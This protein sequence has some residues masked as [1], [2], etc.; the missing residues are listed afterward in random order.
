MICVREN[1]Q[2]K[3]DGL[4]PVAPEVVKT[5]LEPEFWILLKQFHRTVAPIVDAIGNLE[6]REANLAD[7]M[8]ELIK[9]ARNF[10]RLE[11]TQGESADFW[12]HA[13]ITF[14]NRFHGMNTDLHQLALF[15]HPLCRNLA[16]GQA[17]N[18]RSLKDMIKI[19]L[20]IAH[21]QWDWSRVRAEALQQNMNDYYS[22]LGP[23]SGGEADAM[24]WWNS[25]PI[26][27]KEY[28]IKHMAIILF[29][30]VPHAAEVER[31]FSQLGGVQTTRR[32]K[33]SVRNFEAL[34]KIRAN[35]SQQLWQDE[36][37]RTGQI[38]RR[39]HGHMHT[40][41]QPGIDI[42]AAKELEENFMW[43]P[44]LAAQD[45]DDPVDIITPED[46][47][48]EELMAEWDRFEKQQAEEV[49]NVAV[50]PSQEVLSGKVYDF[51]E[52][53]RVEKGTVELYHDSNVSVAD[54]SEGGAD[55]DVNTLLN[56]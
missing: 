7:C 54:G 8:L 6:S 20:T 37:T 27:A 17:A 28:P 16:V 22:C 41:P 30:I 19:A 26:S 33:L 9:C 23:F 34:G 29:S 39:R 35:L 40:R 56:S 48:E 1:A 25:R 49:G 21:D 42:D 31:L 12:A 52:L 5:V 4:S 24:R 13:K 10:I 55:W 14:N 47:S 53:E 18:G 32:C 43:N 3:I 46:I 11:L 15:L 2:R 38:P 50:A 36:R 51:V 45:A 44:P